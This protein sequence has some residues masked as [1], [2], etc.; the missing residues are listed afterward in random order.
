MMSLLHIEQNTERQSL[1]RRWLIFA[2]MGLAYAASI[3]DTTIVHL[4][5]PTIGREFTADL[6]TTSWIVHSYNIVFAASLVI[7]GRLADTYGH[8]RILLM[9]ISLFALSSLGCAFAPSMEWLIVLRA[10][11]ALGGASLGAGGFAVVCLIF[12]VSHRAL[13]LSIWSAVAALAAIMGPV[14]G[15]IVLAFSWRWIFLINLPVCIFAFFLTC[16][17]PVSVSRKERH[18]DV[19]GML[20]LALF[21]TSLILLLL[22]D[23]SG[24]MF[25]ALLT[26]V[27]L[28]IAGFVF[29]ER[30]SVAPLLDLTLFRLQ[31]FTASSIAMF[32]FWLAYQGATLILGLY[33][34]NAQ[35]LAPSSAAIFIVPV[36]LA[37]I[38]TSLF[39]KVRWHMWIRAVVGILCGSIG[40]LG[41]SVLGS[42][43]L[44]QIVFPA[45]LIGAAASL[46]FVSF[47]ASVLSEVPKNKLGQASGI[48]N[49]A[50]QLATTLGA[51]LLLKSISWQLQ[52]QFTQLE[53]Y[54]QA[55]MQV[56]PIT[57]GQR[58]QAETFCNQFLS[59]LIES[60]GSIHVPHLHLLGI[61]T[62]DAWFSQQLQASMVSAFS[63]TWLLCA[64]MAMVALPLAMALRP[65][66]KNGLAASSSTEKQPKGVLSHAKNT[67]S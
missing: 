22:E 30:K 6:M 12:P 39:L 7:A 59:S 21:L 27:G 36:P 3:L 2:G 35:H 25:I 64:A 1:I 31:S 8:K 19:A 46:C 66:Q 47:H 15:G 38:V 52:G 42:A 32:V 13:P 17:L 58:L 4:A 40:F 53:H 62:W 67:R 54:E 37:N 50:R 16:L 60:Q 11:Q 24:E 61:P 41:L 20:L 65:T 48:F 26:A 57:P 44:W 56:V 9:G 5:L 34:L 28:S 43:P 29:I 10:M 14:I 63:Q 33:L 23:W 49:T 18:F 45:L 51:A 55:T